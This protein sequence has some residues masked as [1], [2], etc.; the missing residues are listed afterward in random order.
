M[1]ETDAV[2]RRRTG[3]TLLR[4]HRLLRSNWITSFGA[5]LMTLAVM[6][7][8]T[9][10]LMHSAG[11]EWAGP[12]AG[13]VLTL[14]VPVVFLFGLVCVPAGLF[15]Y[16]RRLRERIETMTDR[17]MYLARAVVVLT[18]INFA[19]IA[20]VGY[21]GVHYMSSTQFCGKACHSAMQPEYVTYQDSPHNRVDCVACHVAPTTAGFVESKLNGTRQLI[22]YLSDDYR[23]PIPTPVE[24]MIPADQ[25]CEQCHWPEKYLGT[26]ILV[27]PH[28][29]EDEA[30]SGYTNVLL[31]RTGGT[32]PD[33]KSVGIHWHVHPEA[34]VEYVATDDRR[35]EIPWVRVVKPDGSHEVFT[36]DGH[37]PE[38]QVGVAVRV[39]DCNDCHNRSAHHFEL[40]AEALDR[41]IANGL[42]PRDLP[43]MKKHAMAALHGNYTREGARDGIR[44]HLQKAYAENG[45][46]SEEERQRLEAVSDRLAEVWLR[47][48]Y[49][50]RKVGWGSYPSLSTHDGC[51]RCHDNKHRSESGRVISQDCSI[52]HVVL[53]ENEEDP[54]ILQTFGMGR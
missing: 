21:G 30:V 32:R 14:V 49:P 19:S 8:V 13:I 18:A 16:R 20:T 25:T 36:V 35:M 23:R 17:P 48:V 1:Q 33:G 9:L 2:P 46:L 4:V 24:H 38:G 50:E 37:S 3:G 52:C 39:M 15:V 22:S 10:G 29:R 47:N 31:M 45:G 6:G 26:K 44:Q 28:Y 51:F 41:D 53:S 42:V 5:A 11:G 54:A 34:K 7:G 12:Y 40:P 27:K 43:F